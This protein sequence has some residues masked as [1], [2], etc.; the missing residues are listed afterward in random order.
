MLRRPRLAEQTKTKGILRR[1]SSECVGSVHRAIGAAFTGRDDVGARGTSVA[2]QGMRIAPTAAL[3]IEIT[4][5]ATAL[6][7]KRC[8]TSSVSPLL[9]VS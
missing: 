3:G 7:P 9:S 2:A 1:G 5:Q 6:R 8:D 4:T